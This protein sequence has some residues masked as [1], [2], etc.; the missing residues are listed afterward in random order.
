M[1]DVQPAP[2]PLAPSGRRRCFEHGLAAG[3]DGK[4]VLCLREER[5]E[6]SVLGAVLRVAA[7]VGLFALVGY[8]ALRVLRPSRDS[9]ESAA[10]QA[11]TAAAAPVRAASPARADDRAADEQGPSKPPVLDPPTAVPAAASA[12]ATAPSADPSSTSADARLEE[13]MRRIPIKIYVT[14]WCP[15]CK[16]ARAWMTAHQYSFTAYDVEADPA[17]AAVHKRLAPGGEVPVLDI[18][19]ESFTGFSEATVEQVLQRH[20][21]KRLGH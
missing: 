9:D 20:A 16:H 8:A 18:E 15:H 17:A 13:E 1:N 11:E 5:A 12:E 14:R 19:G 3:E 4:C 7:V 10:V 6:R 21:R 2:F